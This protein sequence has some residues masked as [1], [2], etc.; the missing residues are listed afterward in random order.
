MGKDEVS[1]HPLSPTFTG[2]AVRGEPEAY[3]AAAVVGAWCVLALVA[4][5]APRVTPALVDV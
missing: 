4:T 3:G 1:G 5:Q 2:A